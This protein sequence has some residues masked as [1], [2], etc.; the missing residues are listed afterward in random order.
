V[1]ALVWQFEI[2]AVKTDEFEAFYGAGGPWAEVARRDRAYLGAS[3]VR[4]LGEPLRYMLTEYWS[5]IVVYEHHHHQFKTEFL[6]LEEQRNALVK[7]VTPL[8]VFQALDVPDRSGPTWS[9]RSYV[10]P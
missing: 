5:E 4:D 2:E 6:L 10:K 1:I 3:F 8:G 7:S 9:T